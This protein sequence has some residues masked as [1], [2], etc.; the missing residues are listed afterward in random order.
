M[1]FLIGALLGL[2]FGLGIMWVI[3]NPKV[4]EKVVV[5]TEV[6]RPLLKYTIENLGKREYKSEIFLGDQISDGVFNFYFDSDGKKVTG[7][8]HLPKSCEKCPVVVQFR[9][10]APDPATYYQ[11]YGTQHSAEI[12]AASGFVSLAP[13]FLGY[14]GSA[15]PSADVFEARFETYTTALNLL[16]AVKNWDRSNGKIGVW[17]HSNGGQIALTTAEISQHTYPMVLW[18]PV[19]AGFPY[20]IL[21]Y[22][23][24]N[25]EGDKQLRNKLHEFENLYDTSQFNLLNY[26]D[27][28]ASTMQLHQGTGDASVP[29]GWS[30]DLVKK[31]KNV[32]YYEYPGADHNLVPDWSVVVQRDVEF[33]RRWLTN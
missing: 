12:F 13:D 27:R 32:K 1:K 10:Y 11:G 6:Q 19:S 8:A 4:E 29:V 14:G 9:G 22:M 31:S 30:R 20:S 26:T 5:K 3:R 16:A 28:I 7:L 21:F 2:G 15:S 23:N 17:G 25:E 24:D 18:A 33:F